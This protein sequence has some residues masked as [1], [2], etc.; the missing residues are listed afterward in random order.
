MFLSPLFAAAALALAPTS[1]TAP[2]ASAPPSTTTP[3][4]GLGVESVTPEQLAKFRAAPLPTDVA[5]RV[6]ALLDVRAPGIGILSPDGA[7]LFFEWGVT[8]VRHIWRV[9]GPKQ[10]PVQLT[11]GQDRTSLFDV[12]PDGKTLV[13]TRDRGGDENWGIYLQSADGGPLVVVQHKP[14]VQTQ[15]LHISGDGKALYFRA[16]DKK[17]DAYALYRYSFATAKID[18]VLEQD[19]LWTMLDRRV[20]GGRA[21]ALVGKETG[22]H[23]LEVF[24]LDEQSGAL[25]PLFGQG[26]QEDYAARYGKGDD[27]LVLTPKLGDARRLYRFDR[28]AKALVALSPESRWDISSMEIDRDRTRI[29]ATMNEAGAAKLLAFDASTGK[30]LRLPTLPKSDVL[31]W[32][33]PTPNGSR[34]VVIADP[35]TGPAQSYVLDWKKGA[36][37]VW[38]TGSTPERQPNSFTAA[39]IEEYPARD[40]TKIPMLV[41]RPKSCKA[42]CPV[43]VDFHGGPEAQAKLGFHPRAQLFIDAGF[44][45]VLPNVRGSD[46]YGKKWVHADDA[47]KRLDVVTDIEDAATYLRKAWAVDGKAPKI[48]VLGGSYGGYS[49][50]LAMTR[51]AGAYDA[52]VAAV[53]I[54]NWLTFL[55][56]TAPYRRLLRVSEYGDPVKD[57]D[58]LRELSPITHVDKAKGPLLI[59]Q[60]ATDPRVPVGEAIQ[61]F[62][63][64]EKKG[65]RPKLIV[66]PDEGH[67]VSK[68][69]NQALYLGHALAFFEEHL[70]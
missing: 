38:H 67:S 64:L 19:G 20:D 60:G 61:M 44:I 17:P 1:T 36:F 33:K 56:N 27:V 13:L 66:F 15:P 42:P 55:E 49:A 10:F 8:G 3:Y 29:L 57:R 11:G 62:G 21:V 70:R 54:S 50:L 59:V 65:L 2:E 32:G 9:D 46:G 51:F 37:E 63:A 6:Q 26:E 30:P 22:G 5:A 45:Y 35:G 40:G 39:V 41:R 48:G 31:S 12:T 52:G 24:E 14:K 16:N 4:K 23:M 25:T 28:K 47:A 43:V 34:A 68:R 53:G 69:E 7:R 18:V 58:A